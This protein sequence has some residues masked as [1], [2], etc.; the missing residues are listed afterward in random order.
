MKSKAIKR[1]EER[2]RILCTGDEVPHR[3]CGIAIA[4][5]FGRETLANYRYDGA[6]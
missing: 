2:G 1:A 3:S 5:T 4:G 6:G